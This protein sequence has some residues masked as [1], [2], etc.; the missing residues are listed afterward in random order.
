LLDEL[1]EDALR[2]VG[3]EHGRRGQEVGGDPGRTPVA[4]DDIEIK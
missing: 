3:G 4:A 1:F 2:E